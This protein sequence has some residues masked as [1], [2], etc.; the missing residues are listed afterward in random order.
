MRSTLLVFFSVLQV[1]I[2]SAASFNGKLQP[3]IKV[4]GFDPEYMRHDTYLAE[5][6]YTD[7][8]GQKYFLDFQNFP[9]DEELFL[10]YQRTT[11][12][13][14][15]DWQLGET[16]VIK[17]TGMIMVNEKP[18]GHL[19]YLSSQGFFPGERLFLRFSTKTRLLYEISL[20]PNSLVTK[21]RKGVIVLEGEMM[22]VDPTVYS[23]KFPGIAPHEKV[24]IKSL[25]KN[26]VNEIGKHTAGQALVLDPGIKDV[27]GGVSELVVSQKRGPQYRMV[28]PWG[29]YFA[30][31]REKQH[32]EE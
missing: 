1:F 16:F 13:K 2:L 11:Q 6:E 10:T 4:L 31:F 24:S 29:S 20:I 26:F 7:P 14:K 17:K 32:V 23:I 30:N 8:D 19:Y 27:T 28:L 18:S 3:K 9:T 12:K 15:D 21:N 5:H 25:F 22:S